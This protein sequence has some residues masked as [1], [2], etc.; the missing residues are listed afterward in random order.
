[1][2]EVPGEM[3]ERPRRARRWMVRL[4]A[5]LG[6]LMLL[7]LLVLAMIALVIRQREV[8]RW[9]ALADVPPVGVPQAP[10]PPDD[11]AWDLL[12]QAA[13]AHDATVDWKAALKP[14][15]PPAAEDLPLWEQDTEALRLQEE[16]AARPGLT[17]PLPEDY[18]GEW[19]DFVPYQTMARVRCLRGWDRAL[20]GDPD[21]AVDDMLATMHLGQ[22]FMDCETALLPAMVGV[23]IEGIALR[24]LAE[25]LDM[26][27]WDRPDLLVR[28]ANELLALSE[29]PATLPRALAW[30]CAATEEVFRASMDDLAALGGDD[31]G[32]VDLTHRMLYR[33]GHDADTAIAW[34][35]PRCRAQVEQA[36][37][38]WPQRETPRFEPVWPWF[39]RPNAG[40]LLHAPASR[41]LI[42]L[43]PTYESLVEREDRLRAIQRGHAL[44]W[45][46]RAWMLERD[47]ELPGDAEELVPQYI[48]HLPAD[49]F[50]DAPLGL[51]GSEVF[52]AMD[53]REGIVNHE[54]ADL[55][56]SVIAPTT[57]PRTSP[58]I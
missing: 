45:A 41:I 21:A 22:R 31:P 3:N 27:G 35:R 47:D 43:M 30:E 44:A 57:A 26:D 37:L 40:Q 12:A 16:A 20:A 24:E 8:N 1:M 50:A 48:D 52:S 58:Q 32:D 42:E 54:P 19:V 10:L 34:H 5:I 56:W 49:P 13:D 11:E 36:A 29:S 17:V 9:P 39:G 4:G 33:F 55:R 18:L 2:A 28:T 38:P 15:G 6:S 23:A 53:G 7:S 14:V 51:R 25:L 46:T